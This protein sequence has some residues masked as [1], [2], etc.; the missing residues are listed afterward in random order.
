MYLCM[1][2]HVHVGMSTHAWFSQYTD[3]NRHTKES[4]RTSAWLPANTFFN[5]LIH[6]YNVYKCYIHVYTLISILIYTLIVYIHKY[7]RILTYLWVN[8][9]GSLVFDFSLFSGFAQ[10][11]ELLEFAQYIYTYSYARSN[12]TFYAYPHLHVKA[13]EAG[14]LISL[15]ASV[16]NASPTLQ[17]LMEEIRRSAVEVGSLSMFIPLFSGFHTSK[18]VQDFFHQQYEPG[19]KNF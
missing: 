6:T 8:Y 11:G 5:V 16:L 2:Q 17:K 4:S 18:V 1:M 13:P 3:G 15:R 14:N 9:K 7:I 19:K 12:L 10:V